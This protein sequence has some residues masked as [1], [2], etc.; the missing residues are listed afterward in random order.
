M[1]TDPWYLRE[2][3]SDVPPEEMQAALAD[4]DWANDVGMEDEDGDVQSEGDGE[5][6]D[7]DYSEDGSDESDGTDFESEGSV[8]AMDD[9]D[10][11]LASESSFRHVPRTPTSSPSQ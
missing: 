2:L 7:T 9:D 11:E 4:E 5:E 1:A 8:S 10:V 6:T 3:V